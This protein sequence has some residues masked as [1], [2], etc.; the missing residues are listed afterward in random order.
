M[1]LTRNLG[2]LALAVYLILVGIAGLGI[3]SV[4]GLGTI[5]AILAIVAGILILVGR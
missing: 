5:A 4:A 3:V 1:R 2:M